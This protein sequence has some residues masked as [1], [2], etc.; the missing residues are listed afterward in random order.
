[1]PHRRGF[2]GLLNLQTYRIRWGRRGTWDL[3]C[4]STINWHRKGWGVIMGYPS[5]ADRFEG[6][7]LEFARFD[8]VMVSECKGF[9]VISVLS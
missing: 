9:V 2:E 3:C 4:T 6:S 1:M 8:E 5:L 7:L